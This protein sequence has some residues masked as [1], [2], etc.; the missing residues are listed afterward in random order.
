[1]G[2]AL[3]NPDG[4]E[5]LTGKGSISCDLLK[6]I[7]MAAMVADHIGAVLF[8]SAIVLRLIGRIAFPLYVWLLVI[9]F[10]HT[11]NLRKYL[12]R[13]GVFALISEVP[14][15]LAVSG[16]MTGQWQNIYFTLFLSLAMMAVLRVI[17]DRGGRYA[18]LAAVL[19]VAAAMLLS[20]G[21]HFDYGS[22]GPVLAAMFYLFWRNK[23]PGLAVGFLI[24]SF[25]GMLDPIW[26]AGDPRSAAV[27]SSALASSVIESC[28]LPAVLIIQRCNGRREQR[29][30][31]L[32]FYAFYPLHLLVLY[33]I[34][35]IL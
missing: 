21:L 3:E 32:F 17:L 26:N 1:M 25:S 22:T 7:A 8:P 35:C 16:E 14:F 10:A 19:T 23:R 15:D 6:A 5:A 34:R 30:G 2:N 28:G 31:K 20:E 11:S 24:F 29:R 9:G 13:L 18:V 12:F 33:G 27:W 4:R